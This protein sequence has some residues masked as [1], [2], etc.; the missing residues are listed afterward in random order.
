MIICKFQ[1]GIFPLLDGWTPIIQPT[2]RHICPSLG[3]SL[4]LAGCGNFTT[5]ARCKKSPIIVLTFQKYYFASYTNAHIKILLKRE[6]IVLSENHLWLLPFSKESSSSNL[7]S[8]SLLF[9]KGNFRLKLIF[10]FPCCLFKVPVDLGNNI[11][12]K[13]LI[14]NKTLCGKPSK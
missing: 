5:K 7:L 9:M 10:C 1:R 2:H 14:K 3:W 11:F 13:T 6:T 12:F 8:L 4:S